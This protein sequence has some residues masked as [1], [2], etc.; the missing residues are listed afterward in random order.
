MSNGN[1][2]N[3]EALI[4]LR[5]IGLSYWLKTGLFHREKFWAIKN[6]SFDLFGGD[7]LAVIGK[8]GVGKSTLLRL[9]GAIMSPDRGKIV[10][11]N[12]STS[13]LSLNLGFIPYLS[14]RENAVLG[15]MFQG[16]TKDEIEDKLDEIIAFADLEE[17]IDQPISTYSSGMVARLGFSVA[18]QL[19][20][21]VLLV[22]EIMGVGDQSFQ[23]KSKSVM[24]ERI[25]SKDTTI[26]L[27]SHSAAEIRELCNRVIWI[28]DHVI[29]AD[30]PTEEVLHDYG[31]FL[32]HGTKKVPA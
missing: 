23:D 10:F 6:I 16:L 1:D 2:T 20:P 11:N 15:G 3:P 9:M 18:F 24:K 17:F 26:V 31:I 4:S 22:D 12:V 25:K 21:D 27:V 13:L 14:G 32:V 19:R 8:N 5:N 28:E 30:G 7:S 29:Q